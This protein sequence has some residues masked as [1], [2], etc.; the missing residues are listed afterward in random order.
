MVLADYALTTTTNAVN[1]QLFRVRLPYY[2]LLSCK[3]YCRLLS[4]SRMVWWVLRTLL[5]EISVPSVSKS[6]FTG[7]LNNR[8]HRWYILYN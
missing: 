5:Y 4:F 7:P 8:H 6:L 1:L 2:L 3:F